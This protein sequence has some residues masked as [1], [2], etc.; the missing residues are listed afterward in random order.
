M[1]L[2]TKCAGAF[3]ML[4]D[5]PFPLRSGVD[6]LRTVITTAEAEAPGSAG[7]GNFSRGNPAGDPFNNLTK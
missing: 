1:K 2:W 5:D 6:K 4:P 3:T 7:G